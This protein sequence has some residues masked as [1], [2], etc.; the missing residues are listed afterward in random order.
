MAT[1]AE[2]IAGLLTIW[3]DVPA[4]LKADFDRWYLTE[5]LPERRPIDGVISAELFELAGGGEAHLAVYELA[6][7]DVIDGDAWQALRHKPD[8]DLGT[9]IRANWKNQTRR[10]YT[11]RTQRM[12]GALRPVEC[13]SLAVVRAGVVEG[14]EADFREWL[15]AEHSVRQLE[16]DGA[17]AYQG[18][19]P[20]DGDFHF[21]NFWGLDSADVARSA[22]WD[23]ARN[24]EWRDR[25]A[26]ARGDTS[27]QFFR[28]VTG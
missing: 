4:D 10:M 1:E 24:T 9:H 8:T 25:L 3:V 19:E 28:R 11:L 21:L 6:S 7:L 12:K 14:R 22:A 5:H 27:Q 26:D 20:V 15:D 2:R 16:V 17:Q 23:E 13:P 18:F